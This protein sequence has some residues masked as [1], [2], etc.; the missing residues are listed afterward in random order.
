MYQ[1]QFPWFNLDWQVEGW[2]VWQISPANLLQH[3]PGTSQYPFSLTICLKVMLQDGDSSD[4]VPVHDFLKFRPTVRN[5]SIWQAMCRKYLWLFQKGK[6]RVSESTLNCF[7][8]ESLSGELSVI[9]TGPW[10]EFCSS[11]IVVYTTCF[12]Y[13]SHVVVLLILNTLQ[14]YNPC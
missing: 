8:K 5:D 14:H 12:I 6:T 1:S 2:R 11:N 13:P 7:Q 4:K 9:Q 10:Q 3:P